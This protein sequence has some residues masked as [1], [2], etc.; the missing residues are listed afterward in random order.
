MFEREI[1]KPNEIILILL[2]NIF[3]NNS[4]IINNHMLSNFDNIK[5]F[6]FFMM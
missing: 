2:R 6:P 5:L 1:F 3:M 4:L